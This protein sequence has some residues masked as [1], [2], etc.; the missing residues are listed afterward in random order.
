MV[1]HGTAWAF[2][3]SP[4]RRAHDERAS[5][6][7]VIVVSRGGNEP[8]RPT[9]CGILIQFMPLVRVGLRS[10]WTSTWCDLGH[11]NTDVLHF[12]FFGKSVVVLNGSWPCFSRFSFAIRNCVSWRCDFL[13]LTFLLPLALF[14]TVIVL[15]FLFTFFVL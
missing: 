10:V 2:V 1:L 15:F 12:G 14:R 8:R 7:V 5:S 6:A 4:P 9:K 13:S 3:G 11:A